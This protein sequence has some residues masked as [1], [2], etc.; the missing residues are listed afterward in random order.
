MILQGICHDNLFYFYLQGKGLQDVRE[1]GLGT[2]KDVFLCEITCYITS[3]YY[4]YNV[5]YQHEKKV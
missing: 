5:I 4:I 2:K 1:K 3:G